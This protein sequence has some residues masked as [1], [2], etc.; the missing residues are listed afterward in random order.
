LVGLVGRGI[1]PTQGLYIHRTTKTS[2]HAVSGNRTHDHGDQTIKPYASDRADT[3]SA[4]NFIYLPNSLT[5]P[6][7][8]TGSL[9]LLP[10]L[11]KFGVAKYWKLET[12]ISKSWQRMDCEP[13]QTRFSRRR[14]APCSLVHTDRRF[15]GTYCFHHQND[16]ECQYICVYKYIYIYIYILSF[17]ILNEVGGTCGTHGRGMC[18]GF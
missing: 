12:A 13:D 8:R 16:D 1:S 6:T 18:T 10:L 3:G 15:R 7:L 11:K 14:T 2:I 17:C 5:A 4:P 9:L